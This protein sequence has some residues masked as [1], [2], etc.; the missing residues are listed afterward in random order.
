MGG[1]S[2]RGGS[3]DGDADEVATGDDGVGGLVDGGG[4]GLAGGRRGIAVVD[5]VV[6]L[7]GLDGGWVWALAAFDGGAGK[8]E[9]GV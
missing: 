1:G 3:A 4:D 2:T 8:L 5:G 6:E 9:G 7:L